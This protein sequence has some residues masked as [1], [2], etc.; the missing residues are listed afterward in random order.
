MFHALL[1]VCALAGLLALT[2]GETVAAAVHSRAAPAAH[3]Q[4]TEGISLDEAIEK[5]RQTYGDVTILKADSRGSNGGQVYRIKFLTE[6]GRVKTVT[7]D[8]DTGELR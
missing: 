2:P 5:V 4:A 7:V 3:R 6:S 1:T 8:A